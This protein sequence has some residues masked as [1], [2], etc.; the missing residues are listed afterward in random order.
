MARF[1]QAPQLLLAI[2]MALVAHTYQVRKKTFLSVGEVSASDPYVTTTMQYLSDDFNKKSND[3][4]NFR[5]VR[6][7]KVQKQ[8]IECF[9]SVFVVP[10]FEKYKILNKNCTD[11]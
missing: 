3:K 7:L 4:Y 8:Q 11:D 1:W 5:I 6:L 2:F 9:Y 10:W